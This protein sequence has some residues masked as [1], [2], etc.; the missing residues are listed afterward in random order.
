MIIIRPCSRKTERVNMCSSTRVHSENA[1]GE[2][3]GNPLLGPNH[4]ATAPT[5][6]RVRKVMTDP[7]KVMDLHATSFDLKSCS[8][9]VLRS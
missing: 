7:R 4:G 8:L 9:Y 5:N 6:A 1:C 3:R 2:G